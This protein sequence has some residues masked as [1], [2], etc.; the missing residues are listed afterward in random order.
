MLSATAPASAPEFWRKRVIVLWQGAGQA[1]LLALK[2]GPGET[3]D[4]TMTPPA[5]LPTPSIPVS[6]VVAAASGEL[7]GQR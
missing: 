1:I 3:E 7:G 2:T 6:T 4:R 5:N